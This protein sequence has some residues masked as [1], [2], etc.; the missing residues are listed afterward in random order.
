MSPQFHDVKWG[1]TVD[2]NLPLKKEPSQSLQDANICLKPLACPQADVLMGS[3]SLS[4][5][6]CRQITTW[7]LSSLWRCPRLCS[8]QGFAHALPFMVM[9][10]PFSQLFSMDL[11]L[12]HPSRFSSSPLSRSFPSSPPP[13]PYLS[14]SALLPTAAL[15]ESS[16]HSTFL[17]SVIHILSPTLNGKVPES[18]NQ[19]SFL[20]VAAPPFQIKPYQSICSIIVYCNDWHLKA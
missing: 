19:V 10:P 5:Y 8:L 17:H 4:M 2:V 18:R 13:S 15:S 9:G 6:F 11:K 3:F 7:F 12:P 16:S 14:L 20:F 1:L